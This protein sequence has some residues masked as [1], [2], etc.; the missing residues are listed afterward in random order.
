MEHV[1]VRTRTK[2][3]PPGKVGSGGGTAR[4][5]RSRIHDKRGMPR[6]SLFLLSNLIRNRARGKVWNVA[7]RTCFGFKEMAREQ[8]TQMRSSDALF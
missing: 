6:A 4:N 2:L 5:Q 3:R 7:Y 1:E 8:I